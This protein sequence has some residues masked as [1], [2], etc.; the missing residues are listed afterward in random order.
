MILSWDPNF[1]NLIFVEKAR[2]D[3]AN[4]DEFVMDANIDCN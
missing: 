2:L 3:S 4:E 1:T